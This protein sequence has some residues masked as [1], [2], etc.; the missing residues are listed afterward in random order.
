MDNLYVHRAGRLLLGALAALTLSGQI[1][2]AERSAQVPR[3]EMTLKESRVASVDAGG[4]AAQAGIHEQDF[5]LRVGN[6]PVSHA[7]N[8]K[9]LLRHQ[10]PG[11]AVTL[12]L[13]RD[14]AVLSTQ[15]TPEGPT[16]GNVF[17]RLALAGVGVLTLMIG[18]LVF[19]KK[20]RPL[21]LIFAS[22]CF[23]MGYLVHPPYVPLEGWLLHAQHVLREGLTLLTPPLF[24]HFFLR[25]P[26]R[27]PLLARHRWLP[28]LL[29]LPSALLLLLAIGVR[30]IKERPSCGSRGSPAQSCSS[31]RRTAT[32]TRRLPG[33]ACG[34]FSGEPFWARCRW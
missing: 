25:F 2:E 17:E 26:L 31:S 7:F 18:L 15:F 1:L 13:Q 19:F 30:A 21:T 3:L 20:P 22:I 5:I 9:T 10:E 6:H 4:A 28:K 24:V 34:S 12:H 23:S 8:A 27:H 11:R 14:A 33:A 16:Q 29:Y 32:P